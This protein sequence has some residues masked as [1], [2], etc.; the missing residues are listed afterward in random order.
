MVRNY[1]LRYLDV[2]VVGYV[3]GG[4]LQEEE[5]LLGDLVVQLTSMVRVVTTNGHNLQ[6][7]CHRYVERHIRVQ[8]PSCPGERIEQR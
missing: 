8:K 6:D 4:R 2:A 7:T 5:R 3:A 1:A